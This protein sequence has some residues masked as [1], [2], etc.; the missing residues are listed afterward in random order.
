MTRRLF[1]LI[2]YGDCCY[3]PLLARFQRIDSCT[4]E[5][6]SHG[7]VPLEN[8][9]SSLSRHQAWLIMITWFGTAWSQPIHTMVNRFHRQ[10]RYKGH[11]PWTWRCLSLRTAQYSPTEPESDLFPK[12]F[13]R[14]FL[15]RT[16]TER[17]FWM[18]KSR[19]QD[20]RG[21]ESASLSKHCA[22]RT[23]WKR[24]NISGTRLNYLTNIWGFY[25][26][27]TKPRK[28]PENRF[29]L[30]TLSPYV[31]ASQMFYGGLVSGSLISITP[32]PYL[33]SRCHNRVVTFSKKFFSRHLLL[34]F[35][36]RFKTFSPHQ[37]RRK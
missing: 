13:G 34:Q 1:S 15:H 18:R 27:F 30:F 8:S 2:L 23:S 14:Y 11:D 16:R 5:F 22:A 19:F 4:S 20:L 31:R 28:V 6:S 32:S 24:S 3:M 36:S 29:W 25:R 10:I 7:K 17:F 21:A 12:W 35:M 26:S 33:S 9:T 37:R